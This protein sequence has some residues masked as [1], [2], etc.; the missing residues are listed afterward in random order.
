MFDDKCVPEPLSIVLNMLVEPFLGPK[1]QG[2]N[3]YSVPTLLTTTSGETGSSCGECKVF[4]FAVPPPHPPRGDHRGGRNPDPS[5]GEHRRL[6][7]GLQ[8]KDGLLLMLSEF[9]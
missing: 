2:Q 7:C 8:P 5:V 3:V 9:Y 1:S 4:S 6:G